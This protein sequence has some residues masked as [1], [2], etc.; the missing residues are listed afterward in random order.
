MKTILVLAMHG[1]TPSDFPQNEKIELIR[2]DS[3]VHSAPD[4]VTDEQK[5]RFLELDHK[6]RTWP[7]NKQ[8]DPFQAASYELAGHLKK[9]SGCEVLVGFNEFCAP[10]VDQA[11]DQATAQNPERVIVLTPMMMPG[12]KHSEIEIPDSVKAAQ[13]RY[14]SIQFEYLWP[15][16]LSRLGCFF[17]SEVAARFPLNA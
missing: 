8:N 5:K 3:L 11:L 17:A 1:I 10:S 2:L 4:K 13:T 6:M 15:Y 16:D 14:P 7:R 9:E 12:G